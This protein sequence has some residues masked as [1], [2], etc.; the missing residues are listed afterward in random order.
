MSANKLP[1]VVDEPMRLTLTYRNTGLASQDVI[2]PPGGV[3]VFSVQV[4]VVTHDRN[5]IA[6]ELKPWQSIEDI[7]AWVQGDGT[8]ALRAALAD[9]IREG[10]R[11]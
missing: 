4:A 5:L 6:A 7:A 1:P 3:P 9:G 10:R 8:D 11:W 2:V